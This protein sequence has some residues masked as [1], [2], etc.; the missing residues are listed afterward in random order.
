MNDED[1]LLK[2]FI[3]VHG[4]P[5]CSCYLEVQEDDEFIT[6]IGISMMK[7]GHVCWTT[8]KVDILFDYL[9]REWK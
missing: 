8:S 9:T 7:D 1:K 3:A 6:P 2:M 4:E 5:T